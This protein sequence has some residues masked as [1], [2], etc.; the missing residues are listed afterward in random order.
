MR[1]TVLD[2]GSNSVH[3]SNVFKYFMAVEEV[4]FSI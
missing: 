2:L 4:R 3:F 1:E